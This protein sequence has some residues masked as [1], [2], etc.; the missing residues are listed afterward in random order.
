MLRSAA[1]A[2]SAAAGSAAPLGL[3][4]AHRT[5]QRPGRPRGGHRLAVVTRQPDEEPAVPVPPLDLA[6][7]PQRHRGPPRPRPPRHEQ[8]PHPPAHLPPQPRPPDIP[9]Q[10]LQ[11][12]L[13]PHKD[14]GW[15]R[16]GGARRGRRQG[17]RRANGRRRGGG[18]RGSGRRRGRGGWLGCGRRRAAAWIGR[19]PWGRRPTWVRRV[20]GPAWVRQAARGWEGVDS[21]RAGAG[22]SVDRLE[23]DLGRFWPAGSSALP[24]PPVAR[25]LRPDPGGF[26]LVLRGDSG[27]GGG[28]G[29]GAVGGSSAWSVTA[30]APGSFGDVR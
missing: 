13:P 3:G 18:P 29:V 17:R 28:G 4:R 19:A 22:L 20:P 10:P 2:R 23:T 9:P 5:Q 6:R 15:R 12:P 27:S 30:H 8:H 1:A 16:Q 26:F 11:L 7:Q 25:C 21:S 14:A 24:S